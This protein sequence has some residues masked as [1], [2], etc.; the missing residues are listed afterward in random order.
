MLASGAVPRGQPDLYNFDLR[1]LASRQMEI[2][3]DMMFA[4]AGLGEDALTVLIVDDDHAVVESLQDFLE[5]EGF[6]V[7]TA[8]DGQAALDLL[9]RGLRPCVILLDLMMPR[10]NGWEFR[11]EQLQDADLKDIPIVVVSAVPL[12]LGALAQLGDVEFVPKPPS[13]PRLLAAIRRHCGD[14]IQ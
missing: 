8:T 6:E 3:A 10:L 4:S 9:R 14:P 12:S 7:V 5:D 13:L 1:Q 11:H 2:V